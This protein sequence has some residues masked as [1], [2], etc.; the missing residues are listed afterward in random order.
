MKTVKL[1]A[2]SADRAAA[3]VRGRFGPEAV[4]LRV[5][6]TPAEGMAAR[7]EVLAGVPDDEAPPRPD[8]MTGL[9]AQIAALNRRLPQGSREVARQLAP[10]APA[11]RVGALLESAGLLPAFAQRVMERLR[12]LH[13]EAPPESLDEEMAL[14]GAVL[15]GAWR[16]PS[17]TREG[18]AARTHVFIGAPG[19]GKTTCLSKWLAQAVLLGEQTARVWR[20]DGRIANTAEALSV[21]AEVLGVAVERAWSPQAGAAADEL[22]FVDLPGVDWRDA[23]AVRELGRRL[24]DFGPAE[25]HLV[26]NAAYEVPLLLAQVAALAALPISD[27]IFTH[28][29]EETR[30]GRLWNFVLGTSLAIRFLSAGQNVPGDFLAADPARLLP[31]HSPSTATVC[32]AP[33][34]G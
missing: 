33:Q 4:V 21:F 14:A 28:L 20:L 2:E 30:W 16:R 7:V 3:E 34:P 5:R 22:R 15:R 9:L 26:L 17:A 29:D 1:I 25:V 8:V 32:A 13:G 12:E 18:G 24:A 10:A 31:L 11:W 6:E 27:L 19:A 23:E